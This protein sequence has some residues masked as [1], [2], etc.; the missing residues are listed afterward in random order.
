MNSFD[1]DCERVP[2]INREAMEDLR[3]LALPIV[4]LIVVRGLL[5]SEVRINT[6]GV[7]VFSLD[8]SRPFTPEEEA[9]IFHETGNRA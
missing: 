4:R 2:V 8:A 9:H 7:N 6:L 1:S 5:N 3:R